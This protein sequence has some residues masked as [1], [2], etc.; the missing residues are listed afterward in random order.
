MGPSL[1]AFLGN[2]WR[3]LGRRIYGNTFVLHS[4]GMPMFK[5]PVLLPLSGVV[6]NI[7]YVGS[8]LFFEARFRPTP[9]VYIFLY[10]MTVRA[11]LDGNLM[12]YFQVTLSGRG[13]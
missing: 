5:L 7:L 13:S 1:L 12:P 9:F 8:G 4:K 6:W 2:S 3:P 11:A 10:A